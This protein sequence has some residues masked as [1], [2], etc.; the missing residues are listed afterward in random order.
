MALQAAY[1][2]LCVAR[3]S[4][5]QQALLQAQG[6][7][8][9]HFT[10]AAAFGVAAVARRT[11]GGAAAKPAHAVKPAPAA[12]AMTHGSSSV[13]GDE[14]ASPA[15]PGHWQQ[16]STSAATAASAGMD[17]PPPG[18]ASSTQQ[19]PTSFGSLQPEAVAALL[20]DALNML[21]RD[22]AALL[23]GPAGRVAGDE[24]AGNDASCVAEGASLAG[25]PASGSGN[26]SSETVA[27]CV[28]LRAVAA[29]GHVNIYKAC[30]DIGGSSG[31]AMET[32]GPAATA[33]R[34]T[35]AVCLGSRGKES[36]AHASEG[37]PATAAAP[38]AAA[39]SVHVRQHQHQLPPQHPPQEDASFGVLADLPPGRLELRMLP[40]AFDE[41]EFQ[42]YTRCGAVQ[43][44]WHASDVQGSSGAERGLRR[45][46]PPAGACA[47]V[48]LG[49][50][51][52]RV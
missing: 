18:A 40:S 47:V 14:R 45:P 50:G 33:A 16:A 23:S 1:P 35:Q 11:A 51:L 2:R 39:S 22:A 19:A 34:S 32:P 13:A 46:W 5:K 15:S 21:Q 10:S 26:G 17:A 42:L 36:R 24:P 44:R 12:G 25:P 6:H 9:C 52:L 38:T 30:D 37:V 48:A 8:G 20:A 43:G 27:Y 28:P 49:K 29:K 41:E 31:L 3:P 4:V 7:I